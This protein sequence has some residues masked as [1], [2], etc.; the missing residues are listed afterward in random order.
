MKK[1]GNIL[2]VLGIISVVFAA[3]CASQ[4]SGSAT[5]KAVF[6]AKDAAADMGSVS[7]VQ[8]T[9]QDVQVHSAAR[10]WTTVSS[11]SNTYDLMQLKA[12][13]NAAL[14]ADANIP[15]GTYDQMRLDVSSIVV[16]DVNG[17]HQA[18]LPSNEFKVV[19]DLVVQANSTSSATFD[20]L[21]DQS[22]HVTGNGQYIFAPVAQIETRSSANVNIVSNSNV[23]IS[24][25]AIHTNIKVGMDASGNVGVGLSIPA[26]ADISI[27]SG[28]TIIIGV[29]HAKGIAVATIT[30]AAANMGSVSSV[31][32]TVDKVSVHSE[33]E[34]WVNISSASHTYDLLQLKAQGTNAFLGQA[35]LDAGTYNQIRVDI[36]R[37]VVT[38]ANGTH[39]AKLPSGELKI[40]GNFVV[41][42]NST[43]TASF[44]FFA[45]ESLHVTGN[46]R[47]I[48]APVVRMETRSNVSADIDGNSHVIIHGGSVTTNVKVGMDANGNIGAGMGISSDS[49][50]SI[51][52]DDKI[53]V[54]A[55]SSSSGG[56]SGS[57]Y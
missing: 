39:D 28:G 17:T 50:V 33:T 57:T 56:L 16:T 42:A 12:Q 29:V 44:D 20:F 54:G 37:V 35:T 31:N 22:L 32:V 36:S 23:Q 46:G 49:N 48:M 53:T 4:T 52:S 40:I 30:D 13:G 55:S 5:G 15:A 8:M 51:G 1:F 43:S 45:N 25:G 41:D 19:G 11:S 26:N 47:Y 27:S 7:S 34:G 2:I 9:V 3:G 38:D 6:A 21:A 24:G 10:G 14:L 18:K